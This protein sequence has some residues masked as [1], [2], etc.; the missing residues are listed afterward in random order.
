MIFSVFGFDMHNRVLQD[1]LQIITKPSGRKG[2]VALRSQ[3]ISGKYTTLIVHIHPRNES[4]NKIRGK[5]L[6]LFH[7]M[8]TQ[9][10]IPL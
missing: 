2:L 7:L 1:Q 3:I 6:S 5:D 8:N 4:L 10:S 9:K